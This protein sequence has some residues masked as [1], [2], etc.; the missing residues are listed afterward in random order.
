MAVKGETGGSKGYGEYL[1]F[2]R[3]SRPYHIVFLVPQLQA[4]FV[5]DGLA[6]FGRV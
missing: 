1:G 5:G 4:D 3:R 2:S 6:L